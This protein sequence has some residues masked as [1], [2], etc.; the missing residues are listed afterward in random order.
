MHYRRSYLLLSLLALPGVAQAQPLDGQAPMAARNR[1]EMN[2]VRPP[3]PVF[4]RPQVAKP[5]EGT[6][7]EL[8]DQDIRALYQELN[9]LPKATTYYGSKNVDGRFG[10]YGVQDW[11]D[12]M[13]PLIQQV[14][15]TL[16]NIEVV[17]LDNNL[18]EV[19]LT[20]RVVPKNAMPELPQPLVAV[21]TTTWHFGQRSQKPLFDDVQDRWRIV[22]PEK[23]PDN[24]Q[25]H[26]LAYTAFS[27]GQPPGSNAASTLVPQ[28]AV[29]NIRQ[30]ALGVMMFV[31]DY[32]QYL[33]FDSAHLKRAIM[34]YAK[35]EQIFGIPG[36]ND[37]FTFNDALSGHSIAEFHDLP[38]TIMLY[39]GRGGAL[40]YRYNGK[41]AVGLMDGH[42]E[43]VDPERARTL[44]WDPFKKTP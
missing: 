10:Y 7:L 38:N 40:N 35:T 27:L 36:T 12:Q 32:D 15:I 44:T 1:P 18:A 24:P 8:L 13:R 14:Q 33:A 22:P 41:A 19:K 42:S 6:P 25:G 28:D 17:K 26:P 39:D 3:G 9:N 30:I 23:L 43:L 16:D 20:T 21:E 29:R 4:Q 11:L 34:P 5:R 37:E 2:E 31:Q